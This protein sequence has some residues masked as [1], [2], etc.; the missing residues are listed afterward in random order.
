MGNPKPKFATGWVEL[1]DEP[2]CVGKN[3]DHLQGVFR[4]NGATLRAIGFGLGGCIEDL[5][6]HRRCRLAF[7]PIVNDFNGR[8]SAEMQIVDMEF[9]E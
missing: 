3:G 1:A 4:Q 9:P 5:K 2:R 8:K 7:E 6:Q